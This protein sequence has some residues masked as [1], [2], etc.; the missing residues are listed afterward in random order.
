MQAPDLQASFCPEIF[1]PGLGHILRLCGLTIVLILVE[2]R[3]GAEDTLSQCTDR[4]SLSS[5]IALVLTS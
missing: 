2:S 3:L 1:Y 4:P 5:R